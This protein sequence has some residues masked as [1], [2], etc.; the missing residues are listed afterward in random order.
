MRRQNSEALRLNSFQHALGM[1]RCDAPGCREEGQHR[2][3]KSRGHLNEYFW[4][5]LGHVREYNSA[6]NWCSGLNEGELEREI[7]RSTTWERPTWPLGVRRNHARVLAGAAFADA[8][9]LFEEDGPAARDSGEAIG[10]GPGPSTPEGRAFAVLDLNPPVTMEELKARYK[11]LVKR[12]HPDA[13]GGDRDAEER[14]K[15]I[16]DAYTTLKRFLS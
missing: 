15:L 11:A 7:R 10:R 5:C 9:G 1:R 16:N 2:A 6:W 4:F 12:H 3:P 14:L 8:F 13:N